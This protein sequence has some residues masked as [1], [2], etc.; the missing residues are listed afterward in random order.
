MIEQ[1]QT[2]NKICFS[3][4]NDISGF[5]FFFR[6]E[7]IASEWLEM[8]NIFQNRESVKSIDVKVCDLTKRFAVLHLQSHFYYYTFQYDQMKTF[9]VERKSRLKKESEENALLDQSQI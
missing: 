5:I 4:K 9:M 2:V 7:E 8:V 1:V 3:L 6:D